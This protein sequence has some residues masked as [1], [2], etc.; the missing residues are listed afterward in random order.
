[1]IE[2][3]TLSR[4]ESHQRFSIPSPLSVPIVRLPSMLLI[5]VALNLSTS[6]CVSNT[7]FPLLEIS[8]YSS[9][10][11]INTAFFVIRRSYKL[12]FFVPCG[13]FCRIGVDSGILTQ[14]IRCF[15]I[16][17]RYIIRYAYLDFT[18]GNRSIVCHPVYCK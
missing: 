9:G 15:R 3:V 12:P 13:D 14:R 2:L 18:F 6:A 4:L 11:M 1:M 16:F 10:I 8:L 17:E 7:T 5:C